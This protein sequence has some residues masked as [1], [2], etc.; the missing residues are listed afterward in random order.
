MLLG[1]IAIAA[2]VYFFYD[3]VDEEIRCRVVELI[4]EHYSSLQVSVRSAELVEDG[5]EIRGLSIVE[6]GAEGAHAELIYLDEVFLECSTDWQELLEGQLQVRQITVRRPKI[7]ATRRPGGSFSTAKLLPLPKFSEHSPKLIVENGTVEIFDPLKTPSGTITLRDVNLS[8][9]V[10]DPLS[11]T[12]NTRPVQGTFSADHLRHVEL[13]GQVDPEGQS[14]NFAGTVEGLDVSP[15]LRDALP[16]PLAVKMAP[17]GNLRGQGTL[18]FRVSYDP[19]S[20]SGFRYSLSGRLQRGRM[21]DPRLPHSLDDLRLRVRLD[22]EGIAIDDLFARCGQGT[23][24]NL[25]A[26]RAGFAPGSPMQLQ[27]EVRRLELDDRLLDGLP[28]ELQKQLQKH[29]Q[30]YWPAGLIDADVKLRF[31]GKTWHPELA[32]RCLNVSFMHRKFP[33][34][35][36]NGKGKLDLKNDALQLHLVAY[37]GSQPVRVDAEIDHLTSGATGWFTAQGNELPLDGKKLLQALAEKPREVVRS[38][39]PRGTANFYMRLDRDDPRKP[40]RQ[41]LRITLNGCSMCYEKFPYPI[42]NIYGLLEMKN[43]RWEFHDLKG[44]NDTGRISCR[45]HLTSP[46][47]GQELYLQFDAKDVALEEELRN[48]LPLGM[49]QVWNGLQPRGKIDLEKVIVSLSPAA[50][51]P[52]ITVRARPQPENTSIELTRFPYRLDNLE[53]LLVY[54]GGK[55]EILGPRPNDPFRAKH[56]SVKAAAVGT[57]FLQPDGRWQ[58][59]LKRLSV[60]RLQLDDRELFRALPEQL[61][62]AVVQLA[63]R[64][65]INLRGSFNLEGGASPADQL[66]SRWDLDIGFHQ[67]SIEVGVPLRNL[68]GSVHLKGAIDHNGF[69]SIGELD[70]D[71]L[72]YKDFQLTELKGPLW[73]DSRRAGFGS[74]VAWWRNEKSSQASRQTPTPLTGR[75]FGGTVRGNAWIALEEEPR[76]GLHAELKQADLSRCAQ[77]MMAGRQDLKGKITATVDLGGVGSSPNGMRGQGNIQ[78]HEGDVYELPLM[79]ALLKILGNPEPDTTAFSESYIDFRIHGGHI[80][81]PQIDFR[82]DVISLRGWGEMDFQSNIQLSFYPELGNS[83]LRVPIFSDLL[84]GATQQIMQIHVAGTL[85]DPR[86]QREAFPLVNQALQELQNEIERGRTSEGLFPQTGGNR[87][88]R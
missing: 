58:L 26:H 78:L 3:R 67:G 59:E 60:D 21:D 4:A 17:L 11:Q 19:A 68:H 83:R 16:G 73:V 49:Q 53:G 76:Y 13:T 46:Q 22:N 15:E 12:P 81:F 5:I 51:Q 43:G 71:S 88:L 85:Q 70:V 74:W 29:W 27:A 72:T 20:E 23:V 24:R 36:E 34:R 31:D 2:A 8:V 33:Y 41:H 79:M 57:C 35:L 63:P 6:P 86:I 14:W 82:G 45:G 52:V 69:H 30:T 18:G 87:M 64:G 62:K 7:V 50:K 48:A 61:K 44:T 32:V 75:L 40:M 10:P 9:D 28:A 65:P 77:E 37:S 54:R 25:S 39:H 56:R 66:R 55:V 80:Y 38:L 42:N 84:G 1:G 47:Q